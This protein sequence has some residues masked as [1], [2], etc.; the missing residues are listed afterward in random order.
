MKSKRYTLTVISVVVIIAVWNF[1]ACTHDP[2]F[3]ENPDDPNQ[4]DPQDTMD[5]SSPCEDDV[6]YFEKQIL[7][8]IRSNCAFSDCHNAASAQD[9]VILESYESVMATADVE[10]FNLNDSEFYEVL[11]E[12]NPDKLMPPPPRLQLAPDQINLIA[13]WILQGAENL[14]CDDMDCNVDNVTFTNHINPVIETNCKG[15]HAGPNP[16]GGVL[17]D[18]YDNIKGVVDDGRLIGVV[19]WT[20]GFRRMP[21]GQDMLDECIIDQIKTWIGDGAP[22]N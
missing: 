19:T 8:I 9:G 6:V 7:P 16:S 22:K 3:I 4:M 12:D 11:V 20:E 13:Q 1:T 2:V 14:Q 5:T 21:Q 10:P 18:G 17:L 15:C